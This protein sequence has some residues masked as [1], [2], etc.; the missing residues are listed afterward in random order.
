MQ[1]EKQVVFEKGKV[2]EYNGQK[3][4]FCDFVT[5]TEGAKKDVYY[6]LNDKELDND[7]YI[8][9]TLLKE[10]I[11]SQILRTHLGLIDKKG[12]VI[13]PFENKILK[14]VANKYL[15]AVR[16]DPQTRSV[17]EAVASRNDPTAAERMVNT[18]AGIRD[19]LNT[20]MNNRGEFLLHDLLSEGTVYTIDGK[21]IFDNQYYSFIGMTSDSFY[22][23]T[24][25][26]DSTIVKVPRTDVLSLRPSD[27]IIAD[28][29]KDAVINP[30]LPEVQPMDGVKDTLDVAGVVVEKEKIDAALGSQVTEDENN[31]GPTVSESS[32]IEKSKNEVGDF[33]FHIPPISIDKIETQPVTDAKTEDNDLFKEQN[34]KFNIVDE[35]STEA[36]E[37][38][39][40][41]SSDQGF[42]VTSMSSENESMS[43][44][45]NAGDVISAV[46]EVVQKNKKLELQVKDLTTK[47]SELE[48][49]KNYYQQQVMESSKLRD[50]NAE[51]KKENS[52][53][54]AEKRRLTAVN[55]GLEDSLNQIRHE[56]GI[57]SF[58]SPSSG[59][60]GYQ[61]VA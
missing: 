6:I 5:V 44:F 56:L 15:L 7:F 45:N 18:S 50:E 17:I 12:N 11:D 37:N 42:D 33:E 55:G 38:D 30:V 54:V 51:L 36:N 60:Y 48:K 16:N 58:I 49:E 59:S 29:S 3:D 21:N 19:K 31:I 25:V 20:E 57:D 46:S 9:S 4:I 34:N 52:E 14:E 40:V 35:T 27:I 61:K 28:N 22:C 47:V 32:E 24:N 43:E 10:A 41:P 1:D 26:S 2:S 23:S 8:A 13:I 39:I 53:L